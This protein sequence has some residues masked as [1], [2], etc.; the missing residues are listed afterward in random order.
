VAHQRIDLNFA[1]QEQRIDDLERRLQGTM[2]RIEE[3]EKNIQ[4]QYTE[5]EAVICQHADQIQELENKVYNMEWEM[6]Q[7][8]THQSIAEM[9]SPDG[10]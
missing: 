5:H 9:L 6:R 7:Q 10:Q 8:P 4:E 2:I 3:L 1:E